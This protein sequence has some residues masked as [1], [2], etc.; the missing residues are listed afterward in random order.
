MVRDLAISRAMKRGLVNA[1]AVIGV[2]AFVLLA[3]LLTGNAVFPGYVKAAKE[4]FGTPTAIAGL[5]ELYARIET[6]PKDPALK[7]VQVGGST[8]A[9][10]IPRSWLPQQFQANWGATEQDDLVDFGH[11]FAYYDE[12][13]SLVGLEFY[14]SRW[15]CFVS[16]DATRCPSEYVS[17]HRL[18][19]KP[20]YVTARISEAD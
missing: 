5:A 9:R 16:R 3:I 13:D 1:L 8:Q 17:L 14:G 19:E 18:A 7:L 20:L 2:M 12:K 6:A 10:S 15:G 4:R 11:V